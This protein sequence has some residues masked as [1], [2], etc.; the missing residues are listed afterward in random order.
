MNIPKDAYLVKLDVKSLYTNIP[1][2]EV[3]QAIA[4]ALE[5]TSLPNTSNR[6]LLK[7]LNLI[8]TCNN[9]ISNDKHYKQLSGCIM[10]NKCAPS[11]A[12]IFM[13]N[14]EQK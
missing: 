11:Y 10:G 4:N 3:I 7:F 6:V 5:S 14:F 1:H 9:F 12:N 2:T 8:L 13:G